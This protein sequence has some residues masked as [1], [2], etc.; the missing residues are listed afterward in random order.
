MLSSSVD[1]TDLI[2]LKSPLCMVC[3]SRHF[4]CLSS[5]FSEELE[6]E[7]TSSWVMEEASLE[8][9]VRANACC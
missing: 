8:E 3:I 1:E 5:S 7:D 9:G 6:I 4:K 2:P